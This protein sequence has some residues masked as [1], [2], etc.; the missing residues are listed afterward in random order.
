M[1]ASEGSPEAVWLLVVVVVVVVAV[2]LVVTWLSVA[3]DVGVGVNPASVGLC[4]LSHA[5]AA[6]IE[7]MINAES[8]A[9]A[10]F[11]IL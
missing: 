3:I 5:V 4:S 1:S 6:R 8:I 2:A 9:V 11:I 7:I 10:F